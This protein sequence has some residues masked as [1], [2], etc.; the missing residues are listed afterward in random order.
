L[1]NNGATNATNVKITNNY[2]SASTDLVAVET[3]AG[4]DTGWELVGNSSSKATPT[5]LVVNGELERNDGNSWNRSVFWGTAAPATGTHVVGDRV[6]N[7][8]P[9]SNEISHWLCTVAGSPGTWLA[10]GGGVMSGAGSPEGAITAA[11]GTLFRRTDGGA[12]TTLY[13]KESGTGNTGWAAK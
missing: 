7:E 12:G 4:G 2:L 5:V 6:W 9:S 10:F 1:V 13:V 8:N 11:V 3:G